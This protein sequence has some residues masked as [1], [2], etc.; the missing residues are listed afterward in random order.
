MSTTRRSLIFKTGNSVAG[1]HRAAK[2]YKNWGPRED[3]CGRLHLAHILLFRCPHCARMQERPISELKHFHTCCHP[4]Q[5]KLVGKK[6]DA[7]E[8]H[9][10]LG[11]YERVWDSNIDRPKYGQTRPVPKGRSK[12][13]KK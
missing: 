2:M 4:F 1:A 11:R 10:K 3:P 9:H 8:A 12:F 13:G 5:M 7:L 6:S